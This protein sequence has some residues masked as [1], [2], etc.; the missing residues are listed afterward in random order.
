MTF[1]SNVPVALLNSAWVVVTSDCWKI[2]TRFVVDRTRK[3]A[4]KNI[5]SEFI[6]VIDSMTFWIALSYIFLLFANKLFGQ[7]VWCV[8]LQKAH[9]A[10]F[11]SD[12]TL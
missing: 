4:Q 8:E 6:V 2:C 10:L 3:Y 1:Y 5:P 12:V 9:I 11:F 7:L